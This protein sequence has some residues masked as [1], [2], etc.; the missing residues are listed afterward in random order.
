MVTLSRAHER[1]DMVKRRVHTVDSDDEVA[2][3][4]PSASKRARTEDS[5]EEVQ[6]VAPADA[7]RK[8]DVKGK[9]KLVQNDDSDGDVAIVDEGDEEDGSQVPQP[10]YEDDEKFEEEHEDAVRAAIEAKRKVQ[11]V[12]ILCWGLLSQLVSILSHTCRALQTMESSNHW[13][14]SNSCVTGT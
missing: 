3:S 4:S 10:T 6:E 1:H 2:H 12:S 14:C 5:D 13:R 8:R 9:G 11:G 7:S